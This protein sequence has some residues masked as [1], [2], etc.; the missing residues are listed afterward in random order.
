MHTNRRHQYI[1]KIECVWKVI[2]STLEQAS[3]VS[4]S[5]SLCEVILFPTRP[6]T[7][8]LCNPMLSDETKPE[9]NG[10]TSRPTF[11][12]SSLVL[13]ASTRKEF[14]NYSISINSPIHSSISIPGW[15]PQKREKIPISSGTGFDAANTIF[16]CSSYILIWI[17][18]TCYRD[19]FCSLELQSQPREDFLMNLWTQI[20][21]FEAK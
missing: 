15:L 3:L 12:W 8:V 6:P 21:V 16:F 9:A 18:W 10:A 13:E 4:A 5:T 14:N 7:R 1:L 2:T 19:T 20:I 11:P 17:S